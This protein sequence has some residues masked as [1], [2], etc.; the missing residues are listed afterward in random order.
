MA[1]WLRRE[2]FGAEYVPYM[3]RLKEVARARGMTGF[4]MLED[5]GRGG[6][7]CIYVMLPDRALAPLFDLFQE[8]E[9]ADVPQGAGVLVDLR[10]G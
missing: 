6:R 1:V 9:A 8:V 3:H 7:S 4:V 5:R 10:T 2:F